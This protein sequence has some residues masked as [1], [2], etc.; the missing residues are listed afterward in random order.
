MV[1]DAQR[2]N[3]VTIRKCSKV[4]GEL[5]VLVDFKF[6]RDALFSDEHF[7]SQGKYR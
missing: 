2:S 7:V 5:V 4:S 3:D 6:F 1:H